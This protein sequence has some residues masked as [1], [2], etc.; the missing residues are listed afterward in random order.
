MTVLYGGN[1]LSIRVFVIVNQN[2]IGC[3]DLFCRAHSFIEVLIMYRYSSPFLLVQYAGKIVLALQSTVSRM[4][5]GGQNP[6]H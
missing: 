6:A 2:K 5:L 4:S 3:F 1:I